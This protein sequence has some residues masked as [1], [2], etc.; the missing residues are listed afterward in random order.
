[1]RTGAAPF[2]LVGDTVPVVATRHGF[3]GCAGDWGKKA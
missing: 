3:W 2:R 1:M